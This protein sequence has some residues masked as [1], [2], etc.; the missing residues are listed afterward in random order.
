MPIGAISIAVIV[1]FLQAQY[2]GLNSPDNVEEGPLQRW[3][4]LD[5]V[6]AVLCLGAVTSLLL[7]LQWGGN[8]KTWH[9]KSIIALFCVFG[10]VLIA[11]L[12]WESS[13][14]GRA[15]LPMH[16][17]K[18]RSQLGCCLVAFWNMLMFLVAIYYLPLFYQA[19]VR[20]PHRLFRVVVEKTDIILV[21]V[22][23]IV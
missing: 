18:N 12:V 14:G 4:Q 8:T 17:F 6:G 1:A 16:L 2:T 22:G 7:P 13:L 21:L 20:F 11:F 19:K 23:T 9:D 10:V 15:L 5:W 3:L